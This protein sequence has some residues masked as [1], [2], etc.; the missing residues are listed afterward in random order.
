MS[1]GDGVGIDL[2]QFIP[3]PSQLAKLR[4]T[5]EVLLRLCGHPPAEEPATQDL[6][7]TDGSAW[8]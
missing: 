8:T 2:V 7:L 5:D 6:D 1:E 4:V 3:T